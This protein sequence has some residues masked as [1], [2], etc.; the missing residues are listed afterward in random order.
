MFFEKCSPD[1]FC[2]AYCLPLL[3][4]A[5]RPFH[6]HQTGRTAGR[7]AGAYQVLGLMTVRRRGRIVG[8]CV[9]LNQPYGSTAGA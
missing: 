6:D 2:S 8:V 5:T 1:S 7:D 9:N 3:L 4:T